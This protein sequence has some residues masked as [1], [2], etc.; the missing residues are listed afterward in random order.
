MKTA[1]YSKND[2]LNKVVFLPKNMLKP[3][4]KPENIK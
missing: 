4:Q 3:I 1:I 2:P